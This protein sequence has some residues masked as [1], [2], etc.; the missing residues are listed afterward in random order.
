MLQ[1]I[2]ENAGFTNI[3]KNL[4]CTYN[5]DKDGTRYLG[6]YLDGMDLKE[7]EDANLAIVIP[8]SMNYIKEEKF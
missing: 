6:L 8:V 4:D 3:S 2:L 7:N 1:N 5:A